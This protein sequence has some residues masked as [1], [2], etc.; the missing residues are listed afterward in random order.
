[1][2]KSQVAQAQIIVI[3]GSAG[4]L[5]VLMK[6]LPRLD[7]IRVP[8]VIVL[9]RKA[10]EDTMLEDIIALKTNIPVKLVDDKM[11]V[12]AGFIY[13]A[14]GGY[15]LLFE[16]NFTIA[17]DTSPPVNYS[18]PSIDVS[19]ESASEVFGANAIG[20]LLSGANNDGTRGLIT[21]Q[22]ALGITVVQSPA[23]AEIPFMP[24]HAINKMT[25]DHI[26]DVAGLLQFIAMYQ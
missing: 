21:I 12:L 25:P 14:P 22:N 8:I 11:A 19:F 10:A 16:K 26:L 9:H 1:M 7:S 24:E 17:L 23:S 2:E 13:V 4:S 5:D 18:R 3:G 6:I 15:H 20:I